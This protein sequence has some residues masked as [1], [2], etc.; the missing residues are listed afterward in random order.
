MII[1][2]FSINKKNSLLTK[3]SILI[4]LSI[5]V[6]MVIGSILIY[7]FSS[8]FLRSEIRK[9]ISTLAAN[10]AISINVDKI[11][12]I[13]K[14]DDENTQEYK[15]I[16]STLNQIIK[17]NKNSIRYCYTLIKNNG[18]V[19][20][21]VDGASAEDKIN[22]SKPGDEFVVDNYD[23]VMEAFSGK[24]TAEE[25]PT[26]D[27]IFKGYLQTGY[28]PLKDKIG[29]VIG[30]LAID[31]NVSVI[32]EREMYLIKLM[33]G[34]IIFAIIMANVFGMV[35]GR[36]IV[37]PILELTKSV[38]KLSV[39]DFD[40][41]I[42]TKR[43]DEI[44]QLFDAFNKM[45][46][47]LNFSHNMLNA[48]NQ[49]LKD[50]VFKATMDLSG[51]NKE[52]RDIMDNIDLGIMTIDKD[53]NINN[54]YSKKIYDIFGDIDI[55]KHG[56]TEL[57]FGTENSIEKNILE[58]WL[59]EIIEKNIKDAS[60]YTQPFTQVEISS[61][62]NQK[63]ELK[64]IE[65]FFYPIY[66]D[67]DEE[68]DE[69]VVSKIM[70]IIKDITKQKMIECEMTKKEQ[71]YKENISQ[72]IEIVGTDEEIFEA[73][74][75]E[76]REL[77]I[78]FENNL[79]ELDSMLINEIS[80]ND[81][82]KKKEQVIVDLSRNMHI[83]KGN[84][85]TFKLHKIANVAHDIES[86]F[87]EVKKGNKEVTGELIDDVLIHKDK[88]LVYFEEI[89]DIYN[90]IS[91]NK[92]SNTEVIKKALDDS[93]IRVKVNEVDIL[94]EILSEAM[95]FIMTHAKDG[96]N[97][98]E[99][100]IISRV[101]EQTKDLI[102]NIRKID[103]KRL[104]QRIPRIV[105]DLSM[106]LNKKVSVIIN[107]FSYEIDKNLFEKISDPVIQII[108]NSVY[109]GIET[110]EVRKI[111]GKSPIGQISIAGRIEENNIVIEISDDGK[112]LN[113]NIIK[114]KAL[115]IGLIDKENAENMSKDDVLKLL[116]LPGF[117][118]VENPDDVSGRGVG[119]DLIKSIIED[120]GGTVKLDSEFNKGLVITLSVP[121]LSK[122]FL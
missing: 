102:G 24:V 34:V 70:V 65:L 19:Y 23:Y 100:I 81:M 56:I 45:A 120:L 74:I 48:Y 51:I 112:G 95:D 121:V 83:I 20:Y 10:S 49:E 5:F 62:K 42:P 91:R 122:V 105:H 27:I 115:Q 113:N 64:Y 7:Y 32:N 22:H 6:I 93:Y 119:M 9:S 77:L 55:C 111:Y 80:G 46:I 43:N 38:K 63:S 108:R 97:Y 44:G 18:K 33:I 90:K 101:L 26:E 36:Y 21:S 89:K 75:M 1:S 88:V 60:C 15:D 109:H 71:D 78:N 103:I 99:M 47:D 110:P 69:K 37:T 8:M 4:I 14:P 73:F 50:R 59:K 82:L 79:M 17:V 2:R 84:A 28:A 35:L 76:C 53:M 29:T 118:T 98:N 31:I 107:D 41:I 117:T 116:F 12:N 67:V 66:E 52:Y 85:R 96:E 3:V 39:G 58:L 25:E 11:K 16:Q 13:K 57:L 61:V 106:Q 30:V 87:C 104:F 68:L 114:A 54:Q 86:I 92:N 94:E 40:V 72:I